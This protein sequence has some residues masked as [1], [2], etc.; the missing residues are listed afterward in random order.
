MH[1]H[2]CAC[3]HAYWISYW[4]TQFHVVSTQ[5]KTISW[6][7]YNLCWNNNPNLI[8]ETEVAN[9]LSTKIFFC[10]VASHLNSSFSLQTNNQD[11]ADHDR[12]LVFCDRPS[13]R[14]GVL[15]GDL[16]T[17]SNS[18][19]GTLYVQDSKTLYVQLFSYD[20]RGDGENASALQHY[21]LKNACMYACMHVHTFA[22]LSYISMA[23]TQRHRPSAAD[24]AVRT[25]TGSNSGL[26]VN[27]ALIFFMI[28]TYRQREAPGAVRLN[29]KAGL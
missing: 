26:G 2:L 27:S 12:S 5:Q 21:I 25:L 10:C 18:L 14:P 8:N 20:A 6:L 13:T 3:M 19:D 4:C 7:N 16:P 22:T 15:V 1:V 9:Q 23:C 24:E 11:Q 17:D 28:C 29:L